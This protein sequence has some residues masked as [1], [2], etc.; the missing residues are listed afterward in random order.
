MRPDQAI[1]QKIAELTK[2]LAG[3]EAR[4]KAIHNFCAQKIRYVAV[5]YG[6]AGYEP[7]QA[8]AIFQNKYGDC[9][10][11]A[12]LLVTMLR[13]AGFRAWPV[14]IPTRD[15][16]NMSP[17]FP[18]MMFNHCIA[19]VS[20]KGQLVFMDPTAETCSF[21]DL[22]AGDQDRTVLVIQDNGY[23]VE[24]TPLYL[25]GHNT[26][27]QRLSLDV[28][29]DETVKG[30]RTVS[31]S[32]VYDQAQR[33]WL[34]YTVP[35]VVKDKIASKIQEIS[36]GAHL[37]GYAVDHLNDLNDPLVLRYEFHGPELLTD[38]GPLRILPQLAGLDLSAITKTDRAYPVSYQMLDLK[39]TETT[40]TLPPGYTIR[41]VPAPIVEENRWMKYSARYDVR[42]GTLVFSQSVE[43]RQ[44]VIPLAEYQAYKVF[45]EQL[46]KRVKQRVVLERN[47]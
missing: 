9:K 42:A 4:L 14:L 15:E 24:R 17:D 5:E 32:G 21:G 8:A 34:L 30:Q 28:A 40:I 20:W 38:A 2:G 1:K 25:A 37:D 13:E 18:S 46:G 6:Q 3:D 27:R 10:D 43:M 35:D 39:D 29:A 19:A 45:L 33:Y 12:I 31:S 7:H 26:I 11:Q 36:I 47:K 44:R 16:F 41:Y 22:P 23:L